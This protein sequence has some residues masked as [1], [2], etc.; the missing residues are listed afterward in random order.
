MKRN[1]KTQYVNEILFVLSCAN[2]HSLLNEQE[3]KLGE[4]ANFE[5][6]TLRNHSHFTIFW[7]PAVTP[8]V[9]CD[10]FMISNSE[11]YNKSST[12]RKNYITIVVSD[13]YLLWNCS[14]NS[15][16]C[17]VLN[18]HEF[19]KTRDTLANHALPDQFE[20]SSSPN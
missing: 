19:E 17:Y 14:N 16:L 4:C 18:I 6:H 2:V 12:K 13:K 7:P 15:Q 5:Y 3:Q 20:S 1:C 9:H 11:L 8:L 10:S